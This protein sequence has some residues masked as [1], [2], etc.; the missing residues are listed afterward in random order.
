[1]LAHEKLQVYGKAIAFVASASALSGTWGKKHAVVDQ[2]ER[3]SESLILNLA[4]SARFG[5]AP[6]KLKALDYAL[7]SGL[8]CSLSGCGQ[9][10]GPS[11]RL[12]DGSGE[13][14]AV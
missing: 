4:D 1:M 2:L 3:A 13:T 6:S 7:G 8:E 9:D 12:R 11:M 14:A 10:Q 5:S